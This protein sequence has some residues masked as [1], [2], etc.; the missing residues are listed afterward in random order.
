MRHPLPIAL[1]LL[2]LSGFGC[3]ATSDVPRTTSNS[4]SPDVR[5][6]TSDA[7][8]QTIY[9]S[10]VINIHDWTNP[11]Q[12]IA[13]IHHIIDLHEEY[14]VPVDLY[15][16]DEVTQIYAAQAPDLIDRMKTS[17]YVAV[18]YHIRPPSPYYSG[19]H[20]EVFRNM[21]NTELYD[22]LMTYETHAIDLTT[23]EPTDAAGGYQ[24]V[25]DLIGYPPIVAAQADGK[26]EVTKT[27][28]QVYADLGAQFTLRHGTTSALGSTANG[29]YLRPE[30]EEV[31]AYERKTA[32]DNDAYMEELIAALPETR[33][34]FINLKWH[35][36]NFYTSGTPWNDVYFNA[37]DTPKDPPYDITHW[38]TSTTPKTE[39]QQQVQWD[40]YEDF[41]KYVTTHMDTITVIN[42]KNLVTLV[43]T[44]Q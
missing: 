24:Y 33:P 27:L 11:E 23:G 39:A 42:A 16:D 18:S 12:S 3:T 8:M 35:E 31:K 29:L 32:T 17:P 21:S 26:S 38:Q 34:A 37:N 5:P 25:K 2:T 7:S 28:A 9:T 13:T 30:D 22:A 43:N 19:F 10:F 4:A 44:T 14:N 40:R 6:P 41:L 15:L 1:L 36:D 20:P